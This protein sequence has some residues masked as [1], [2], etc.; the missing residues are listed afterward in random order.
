MAQAAQIGQ[1]T[2]PKTATQRLLDGVERVGNMDPHPV[3]IFLI[4]IAIVIVLSVM[5]SA[6]GAAV[7]YDRINPETHQVEAATTEIRSLLSADGIRFMYGALIP[8]FMGF[9]AVGL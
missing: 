7:T 1:V 5:L 2:A 8:N 9:T 3:V 4:L 6:L